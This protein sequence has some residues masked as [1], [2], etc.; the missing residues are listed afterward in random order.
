VTKRKGGLGEEEY[1]TNGKVMRGR[2]DSTSEKFQEFR[3]A[4]FHC[5]PYTM[6]ATEEEKSVEMGLELKK[7]E[8]KGKTNLLKYIP[9]FFSSEYIILI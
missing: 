1:G 2:K 7:R 4:F 6:R 8:I 9:P 3:L 5:I